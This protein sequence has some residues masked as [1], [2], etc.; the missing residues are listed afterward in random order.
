MIVQKHINMFNIYPD[1]GAFYAP[2]IFN[3][4]HYKN[5]FKPPV[6]Y[7]SEVWV[8]GFFGCVKCTK[9]PSTSAYI[10]S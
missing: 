5:T 2:S 7:N 1:L 9:N 6:L 3:L 8:R 10:P 4:S